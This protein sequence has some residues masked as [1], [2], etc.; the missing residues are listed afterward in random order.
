MD[1]RIDTIDLELIEELAYAFVIEIENGQ[2]PFELEEE[3][4]CANTMRKFVEFVKEKES[5]A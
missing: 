1:I 5:G 4:L 2:D 3:K